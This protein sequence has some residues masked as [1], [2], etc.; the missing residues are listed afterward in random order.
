MKDEISKLLHNG[1][2]CIVTKDRVAAY[3]LNITF[4]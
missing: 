3:T 1:I 2:A 4:L